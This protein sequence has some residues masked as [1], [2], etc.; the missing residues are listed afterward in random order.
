MSENFKYIVYGNKILKIDANEI[1]YAPNYGMFY[2][3]H[4][5]IVKIFKHA[6]IYDDEIFARGDLMLREL[7]TLGSIAPKKVLAVFVAAFILVLMFPSLAYYF[8]SSLWHAI[9]G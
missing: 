1:F 6:D 7:N 4:E 8:F 5:D 2:I 3:N 9:A